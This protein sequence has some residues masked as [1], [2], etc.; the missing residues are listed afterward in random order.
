MIS[1]TVRLSPGALTRMDAYAVEVFGCPPELARGGGVHVVSSP[2]RAL[3]GWH[4]YA[5]PVVAL[6]FPDGAVVAVRPDL[7]EVVRTAMGSDA[8]Q[9]RLDGAAL[10]RLHH[11]VLRL[12]P[13]AFHLLGYVRVAEPA[14]FVSDRSDARAELI[15]RDDPAG[16]HL[17]HRFDGEVFG[18]RG[19]RGRLVSWAALKLKS[20]DAWEVAVA[21]EADYRGRGLARS[22]VSAAARY[23]LE[24]GR[25]CL[26]LHDF[27]NAPSAFVARALGFQVYAE[28]VLAEY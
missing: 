24:R 9:A 27:D 21:T 11:A 15:P 5:M 14:T 10:R 6:S 19:P 18:V 2:S 8:G 1:R 26:Y 4:G 3:P 22:V 20:G 25:L 23:T 28:V 12:A 7:A 17:R 13:S 16:I